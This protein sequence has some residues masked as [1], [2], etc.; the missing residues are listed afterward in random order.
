MANHG[1]GISRGVGLRAWRWIAAASLALAI[2]LAGG[3][4][5]VAVDGLV[6]NP[7]NGHFY[8]WV[9]GS[10]TWPTA[11]LARPQWRIEVVVTAAVG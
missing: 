2:P 10:G 11:E 9:P 3:G 1:G 4:R 7:G 8:K 6:Y 5:A